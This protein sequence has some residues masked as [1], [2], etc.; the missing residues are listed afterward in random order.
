M[1]KILNGLV[2]VFML[3]TLFLATAPH[4]SAQGDVVC[5]TDVVVQAD[6]WLSNLADKFYGNVLAFPV[7]VEATNAQA[8][9]D[10]SYATI[11]DPD[12]IEVGWKLC[13]PPTEVAQ[14][15][16]SESVFTQVAEGETTLVVGLT[17]D[18]VSLDPGRG[19]EFHANS[20]NRGIYQTL[21]T[22][23]PGRLDEIVP[24]LAESWT[25][26]DD[27]L[28]YT[29]TLGEGHTFS[30]GRPV[31]AEDAAFT[32]R[33]MRNLKGNP[34]FLAATIADVQAPDESTVV[35]TLSERDP[36]ILAKLAGTWFGVLDSTEAIAQGASDAENADEVDTAEQWLNNNSIG[37]GPYMLQKWEPKVEA[38][39]VR[40]PNFSSG[41]PADI[42][43]VIFRTIADAAAQKL[44]LEAGDLDI[45]LD[46]SA[47]QVPSLK[48]APNVEVFEAL[49]D[50]VFFLL[51]NADPEIGGPLAM[52]PVQDAI[53]LATDYEGMRL[54]VG[55]AAATPVNISPVNWAYALDESQAPQRDVE[56]AK[57]KLAEAGFPDGL[58]I[59]LEYPEFSSGG[60][61]IGTLAQ[62][63]QADLAE[64]GITVN[65]KPAELGPALERYRNGEEAFGLW[66]WGP[67]FLDPIDRLSFT[68]GGKV[69]LRAN[70]DESDASPELVAAVGR[71]RIAT[72]PADRAEAFAEVQEIMK[73]ESVFV[74]LVQSGTQVAYSTNVQNFVYL[75]TTLGRIDPYLMSK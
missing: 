67:D 53:R 4:A 58:T 41:P 59:D 46:I 35:I 11:E 70:W 56:A 3:T 16:L 69:G 66:L 71:A 52:D 15:L 34:S 21:V 18:T 40:N 19:Y 36:A 29:F 33:R 27:G 64:A 50:T 42:D 12:V 54:L 37:S 13:V 23:P 14:A 31:T 5:E 73:D 51:M 9:S 10:D 62:K 22:F 28:T 8:A 72:D 6:D 38:I 75:G 45:G 48:E 68:P 20:V 7:I 63:V 30:T 26:S 17:E 47:D 55:G 44:A 65:L 39:L 2:A 60:V 25:I 61:A 49:S 43:R 57:A 24:E 1:K 32:I 74:F